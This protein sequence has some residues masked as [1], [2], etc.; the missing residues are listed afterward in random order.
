MAHGGVR[1]GMTVR[2]TSTLYKLVHSVSPPRPLLKYRSIITNKAVY[3][4]RETHT[5][6]RGAEG[7]GTSAPV[8]ITACRSV[9]S[10]L[11]STC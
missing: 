2:C 10:V 7:R 11:N 9:C 6:A 1:S 4:L 5:R 8:Y 3:A